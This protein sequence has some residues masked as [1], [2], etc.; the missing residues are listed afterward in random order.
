MSD[1]ILQVD[2]GFKQRGGRFSFQSLGCVEVFSVVLTYDLRPHK[3]PKTPLSISSVFL[4]MFI[5][6]SLVKMP[7]HNIS[8]DPFT[9]HPLE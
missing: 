6:S 3:D 4:E 7:R 5:T 2:H 9:R 8:I 1:D